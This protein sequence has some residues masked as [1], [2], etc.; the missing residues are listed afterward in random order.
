MLMLFGCQQIVADDTTER[1]K[2]F[3]EGIA[4]RYS[5]ETVGEEAHPLRLSTYP[6]LVWSNPARA[7]DTNGAF[8]IWTTNGR[9]GAVGTIF[10][11][12]SGSRRVVAHEFHSLSQLPLRA[13][14]NGSVVWKPAKN[15]IDWKE[16]EDTP[17][18]AS[19]RPRR[20]A[21]MRAIAREFVVT[22][23]N[24]L[25]K[26]D[27]DQTMRLL[28]QPLYRYETE[29]EDVDGALFTF[30]LGTD[31]ECLLLLESDPPKKSWKMA[32]ARFTH[33]S[34]QVKRKEKLLFQYTRGTESERD[35]SFRYVCFRNGRAPLTPPPISEEN[36]E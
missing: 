15:G 14:L 7:G 4:K 16:L 10:S 34:F 30:V 27:G 11:Y 21:Q 24:E 28:A 13:K 1:W 3:Y 33:L 32:A 20:L 19:T 9:P 18:P 6:A 36:E 25:G 12:K 31:P 23:Q 2:H 35:P 29:G 22:A 5:I 17:Q 8:W 26:A